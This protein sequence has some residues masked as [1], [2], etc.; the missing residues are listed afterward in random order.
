MAEKIFINNSPATLQIT[1]FIRQGESPVN[2]DGTISF[3]LNPSQTLTVTYGDT[4]N[5]F[6]NGILLFTIF[7]G[8]LY[9]KIQFVTVRRS[10][11]DNLLNTN[12]V[13]TITKELTDYVISGSNSF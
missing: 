5:I 3:T 6:L 10:E 13:I 11:L 2:Q 1:L 9:S 7:A 8:D 12:N 4:Q